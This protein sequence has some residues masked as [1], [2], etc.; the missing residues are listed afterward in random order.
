M[1]H[2]GE[3]AVEV[4]VKGDEFIIYFT[5]HETGAKITLSGPVEGILANQDRKSEHADA[6]LLGIEIAHVLRKVTA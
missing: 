6:H 3:D 1:H 5:N 4:E 2:F